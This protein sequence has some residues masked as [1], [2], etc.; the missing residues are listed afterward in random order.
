MA[1]TLCP[2]QEAA[3]RRPSWLYSRTDD[4]AGH[5]GLPRLTCRGSEAVLRLVG[6]EL[7]RDVRRSLIEGRLR[8]FL[9]SHSR[10]GR[11]TCALRSEERVTRGR[12]RREEPRV[13]LLHGDR[14]HTRDRLEFR[15]VT[16]RLTSWDLTGLRPLERMLGDPGDEVLGALLLVGR[17]LASGDAHVVGPGPDALAEEL[18]DGTGS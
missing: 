5:V 4:A 18:R 12:D 10:D 3:L 13:W 8:V 9:A 16:D 11:L 15:R 1:L 14:G 6:D 17:H 7:L 2:E